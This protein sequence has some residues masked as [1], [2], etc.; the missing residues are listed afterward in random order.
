MNCRP[1][2]A[3]PAF[4]ALVSMAFPAAARQRQEGTR[5]EPRAAVHQ[6]R[7]AT[8]KITVDGALDEPA[9]AAAAAIELA[10]EWFPGDNAVPPVETTAYVTFDQANLFIGVRAAD[11]RPEQI[12][13]HLMDRDQV[14]TLV[15]DDYVLV[16]LDTFDDQ[17]RYFQFRVNPLGVQ[18]DA[19]NSEVDRSEDWS[20]DMIW[21]SRGRITGAGYEVEIALPFKQLRFPN[22]AGRQTWGIDVGR[23]YPR[24][25]RHR[26]N[27]AGRDRNQACWVCQFPKITGIEGVAPGR[28][29]ELDPTLTAARTDALDAFPNGEL[30]AGEEETDAGLTVRWGITPNLTMTGTVNPDFSQVEA[31]VAQLDLN[32]RFAL[33]FP[34]KRPFFLEGVDF[35]NVVNRVV[36]TRTLVDPDWGLKLTGKRGRDGLGVFAAEDAVNSLL[37]PSNQGSRSTLLRQSVTSTVLRYRRDVGGA[38]SFGLLYT[39]REGGDYRNRVYGFDGFFRPRDTD[40]LIVQYLRS[41]TRYPAAVAMQFDQPAGAF[42]DSLWEVRYE[43]DT[44]QWNWRVSIS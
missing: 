15:L 39:G 43:I 6:V 23:S 37:F 10:Y 34:E 31:D 14:D 42:D 22:V 7:P 29:L 12:R 11:P 40:T 9:W 28:N 1:P 21:E 24:S 41:D 8:S 32:E 18:A 5:S 3:V 25:S 30:V 13:A 27:A 38:S 16:L 19:L 36:F 4:V 17:R 35:F 26:M 44:R 2:R 20:W 33:F